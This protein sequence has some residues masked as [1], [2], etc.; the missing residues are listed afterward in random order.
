MR[1]L[2]LSSFEC[3]LLLLVAL[4]SFRDLWG[5][6]IR[7]PPGHAKLAQTPGSAQV[8]IPHVRVY[9]TILIFIMFMM[10][11]ITQQLIKLK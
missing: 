1:G 8:N 5:E 10:G 2:S 7:P 4:L 11:Y 3:H 6:G 9:K